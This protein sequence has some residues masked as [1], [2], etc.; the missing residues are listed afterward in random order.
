MSADVAARNFSLTTGCV[1][2]SSVVS[3]TEPHHTPSA[4]RARAAAIWRPSAIPPAASTG[5]G[6]TASTTCGTSTIVPISP[7]CP[8]ASEP[9]AMTR[10]TPAACWRSAWT[11][12]PTRPATI[13][14]RSWASA[15]RKSGAGPR[16]LATRR[17][18]GW[19]H[20]MSSRRCPLSW[21]N[22][23][24]SSPPCPDSS[25]P[26][27]DA[28]SLGSSS[29]PYLAIRSSTNRRCSSGI[30]VGQRLARHAALLDARVLRRHDDV[31]AVGLV[32]DVL[33]DPVQLDLELLGREGD[34]AEHAEPARLAHRGDDVAAVA[35]GEDRELDAEAVAERGAHVA[36]IAPPPARARAAAS[37]D[38]RWSGRSGCRRRAA[39]R[40]PRSR[41]PRC[42]SRARR[43][44]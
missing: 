37:G 22:P 32:A 34:G 20:T 25:T 18:F 21:E 1:S 13:T 27:A 19:A 2:A 14:P 41:A 35:E 31:D 5:V 43:R 39:A 33:V 8:P 11:T 42:A 36:I 12:V 24:T 17:T 29:T 38:V 7:V 15:T 3:H 6:A 28:S 23:I 4:P 10:S 26:F 40:A 30:S 44:A 9:W 16:A